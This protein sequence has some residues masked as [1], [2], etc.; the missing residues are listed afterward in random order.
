MGGGRTAGFLLGFENLEYVNLLG[1]CRFW[2]KSW[3]Y[4]NVTTRIQGRRDMANP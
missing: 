2:E 3:F 1:R 4:A